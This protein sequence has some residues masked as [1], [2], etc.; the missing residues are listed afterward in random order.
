MH[1]QPHTSTS[2]V[3]SGSP[4]L[5]PYIVTAYYHDPSYFAEF[6]TQHT[7]IDMVPKDMDESKGIIYATMSGM[8]YYYHEVCSGNAVIIED[9]D[10]LIYFGHV[11]EYLFP[12]NTEVVKGQP[13]AMMGESGELGVCV[14]GP[15]LHYQIS[16][17]IDGVFQIINPLPYLPQG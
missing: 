9:A 8:G 15:H 17:K 4:F 10:Y 12:D 2:P 5:A 16:E 7:G 1:I 11:A 13:I 3:P 14:T 6:H